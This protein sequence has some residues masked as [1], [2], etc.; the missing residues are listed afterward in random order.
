[1]E[2]LSQL[3]ASLVDVLI[4][5]T[6]LLVLF[7]MGLGTT[8]KEAFSL[9]TQPKKLIIT[10]LSAIVFVIISGAALLYGFAALGIDIPVE[11]QIAILLLAGAAGSAMVPPIAAQAGA[12]KTEAIS[13]MITV[14]I[15]SVIAEPIVVALFFGNLGVE[16]GAGDVAQVVIRSILVPLLI[17]LAIA[18]WWKR[19]ANLITEPL[20]KLAGSLLKVV[21]V[22]IILKDLGTMLSFGLWNLLVMALFVVVWLAIGYLMGGIGGG[23]LPEKITMSTITAWRNGA[24]VM[25]VI[26]QGGLIEQYPASLPASV[27]FQI[28]NM[29]LIMGFLA[30]V[31]KEVKTPEEQREAE[32][33]LAEVE[34]EI[35]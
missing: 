30:L 13:A 19:A 16:I 22:L 3:I 24:I 26:V 20:S 10:L 12:S 9:W 7:T 27:A 34:A 2:E 28:I 4:S 18:T 15:A 32:A 11:I 17:G 35:A 21:I 14:V 8:F 29:V 31:A 5:F 25:M 23:E 33:A 1:M 6:I